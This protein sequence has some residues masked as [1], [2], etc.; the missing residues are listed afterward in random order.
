MSGVWSNP[1]AYHTS[2][3]ITIVA[4]LPE[5]EYRETI[6]KL[7][8]DADAELVAFHWGAF[9]TILYNWAMF[10]E[11]CR[12]RRR[13]N[14]REYLPEGVEVNKASTFFSEEVRRLIVNACVDL[15]PDWVLPSWVKWV[16]A[17]FGVDLTVLKKLGWAELLGRL[18][19]YSVYVWGLRGISQSHLEYYQIEGLEYAS[20]VASHVH[21]EL[22]EATAEPLEAALEPL[23]R[24]FGFTLESVRK[25]A[26]EATI[27]FIESGGRE[28]LGLLDKASE[29]VKKL[30]AALVRILEDTR[31][32][33][34]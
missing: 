13:C 30:R 19:D 25:A 11:E 5:D 29:A 34:A 2:R 32:R 31:E 9:N 3:L 24:E 18:V 7:L 4:K 21:W 26:F 20:V 1:L 14:A 16:A 28:R 27:R 17:R 8:E 15:A 12:G 23:R 33:S 6:K 10:E 22:V